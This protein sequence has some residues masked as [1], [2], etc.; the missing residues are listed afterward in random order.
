MECRGCGVTVSRA[1]A[2]CRNCWRTVP[3]P[4]R[5]ELY[6]H[7]LGTF[8]RVRALN[9]IWAW[10]RAKRDEREQLEATP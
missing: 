3:E 5:H 2:A 8:G 10:Q 9:A 4:L 7:K 6:Q 1:L